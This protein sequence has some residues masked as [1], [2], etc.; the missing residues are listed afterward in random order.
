M[1]QHELAKMG[2]ASVN[3]QMLDG[4]PCIRKRAVGSNSEVY[5]DIRVIISTFQPS[6]FL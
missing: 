3:I 1:T 6:H 2:S 5:S 4:I